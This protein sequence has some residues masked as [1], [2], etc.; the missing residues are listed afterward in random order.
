MISRK[1]WKTN[2][3]SRDVSSGTFEQKFFSGDSFNICGFI[4]V[5]S[6]H[7]KKL[8]EIIFTEKSWNFH[9]KVCKNE[10]FSFTEEIFREINSLVTNSLVKP[11]ASRNFYQKSVRISV[12]SQLIWKKFRENNLQRNYVDF[13]EFLQNFREIN[14]FFYTLH[15]TIQCTVYTHFAI[16]LKWFHEI[17]AFD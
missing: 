16:F 11:L 7:L 17:F 9:W 10:K 4:F 6:D 1:I 15:S 13:T 3:F 14:A 5:T 8:R 2:L 12:I